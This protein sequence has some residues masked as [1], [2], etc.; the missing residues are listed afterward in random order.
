MRHNVSRLSASDMWS[1][2]DKHA[3][4]C[5]ILV[6]YRAGMMLNVRSAVW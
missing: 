3:I 1:H 2:V 5:A 6:A 4:S